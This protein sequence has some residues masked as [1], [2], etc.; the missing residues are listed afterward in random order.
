M[1]AWNSVTHLPNKNPHFFVHVPKYIWETIRPFTKAARREPRLKT[2]KTT[3]DPSLTRHLPDV[4]CKSRESITPTDFI[5]GL[6]LHRHL[7][8]VTDFLGTSTM[9][10]NRK[11]SGLTVVARCVYLQIQIDLCMTDWLLVYL[12]ID[13]SYF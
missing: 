6:L 10:L 11:R 4:P 5:A 7:E 12:V 3:P 9:S 8:Q 13:P 2:L 1:R